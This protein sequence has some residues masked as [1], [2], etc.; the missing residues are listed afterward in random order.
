VVLVLI[1]AGLALSLFVPHAWAA[2]GGIL[3]QPTDSFRWAMVVIGVFPAG[4]LA[5]IF[6]NRLGRRARRLRHELGVE[7]AGLSAR[8]VAADDSQLGSLTLR[9]DR[10]GLVARPDHLVQ[11]GGG[12]VIPI[13]Q[14]PRAQ[15]LYQSHLL[16][17]GAQ[18]VVVEERFGPRPP[19]GG[20][21]LAGGRSE[22]VTFDRNLQLAV[23]E[24]VGAML[25]TTAGRSRTA[26]TLAW[27]K[28]S[29]MRVLRTVLD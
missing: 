19:Y 1:A 10:V 22:H 23:E 14:K 2:G 3:S 9:A 27:W 8:V 4:I 20:V 12:I 29:R 6:G 13:E 16:E 21:V 17:L 25:P 28:V 5:V 26:S 7:E 15:R 24:A 18:L 11:I